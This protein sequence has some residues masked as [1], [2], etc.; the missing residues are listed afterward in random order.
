MIRLPPRSTLS[1]SSAA[2]DV[3]KRQVSTQSTWGV[4]GFNIT[5]QLVVDVTQA[6][7]INNFNI[8]L[9]LSN[10][11]QLSSLSLSPMNIQVN[12]YPNK[13]ED[14]DEKCLTCTEQS[15]TFC[16]NCQY[17]S[18]LP[19]QSLSTC[20]RECP[21]GQFLENTEITFCQNC[22]STCKTCYGNLH[23]QCLSCKQNYYLNSGS[24][25]QKCP[26]TT[27]LNS[28]KCYSNQACGSQC[29][30]CGTNSS[31]CISCITNNFFNYVQQTCV[32]ENTGC[33]HNYYLSSTGKC[34]RCDSI[35][36]ECIEEA[37]SC[38]ICSV[39]FGNSF[40]VVSEHLCVEKCPSYTY[41]GEDRKCL[42][43]YENC[44]T[45]DGGD[46]DNCLTCDLAGETPYF[47]YRSCVSKCQEDQ[48]VKTG[49]ICRDDCTNS[50]CYRCQG[51]NK[52]ECTVCS[53]EE[54]YPIL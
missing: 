12:I 22:Y 19:F 16:I 17:P 27:S 33:S 45:C 51:E 41:L 7:T 48:V 3:Y 42:D 46:S 35:C 53:E 49:K 39:H 6:T 24:C 40:H 32:G 28:D 38:T 44:G 34:E 4:Y 25:I 10:T 37:A 50:R 31:Y 20:V 36:N 9:Y 11:I 8:S 47:N 13:T 5:D 15:K 18:S 2:S 43:C 14:C 26:L 30:S 1:S 21:D 23:N 54:G 52:H 29:S